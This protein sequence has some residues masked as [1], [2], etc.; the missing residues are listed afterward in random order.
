M[1]I[2]RQKIYDESEYVQKVIAIMQCYNHY[3]SVNYFVLRL[4]A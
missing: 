1:F 2:N 4:A 3:G